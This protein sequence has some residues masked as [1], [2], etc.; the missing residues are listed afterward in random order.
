MDVFT[1][2]AEATLTAYVDE[3][4]LILI[5][6][7]G[8][9][10]IALAALAIRKLGKKWGIESTA[11]AEMRGRMLAHDALNFAERWARDRDKI[12]P[13]APTDGKDKMEAALDFVIGVD[14]SIGA[15]KKARATFAK[16]IEAELEKSEGSG[17]G[18][19]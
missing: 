16:M 13:G 15:S 1:L 2:L 14:E 10:L 7:F 9:A 4:V 17:D 6:L 18:K 5:K 11:H 19:T 8:A 12:L 3:I